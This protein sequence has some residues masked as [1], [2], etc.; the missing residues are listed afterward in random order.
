VLKKGQSG[1][2][3]EPGAGDGNRRN[4]NYIR[5]LLLLLGERARG[6]G[7]GGVCSWL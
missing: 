3:R 5:L 2:S 6:D 4:L 1:I 7:G